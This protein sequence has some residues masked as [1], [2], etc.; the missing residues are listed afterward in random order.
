MPEQ[1]VFYGVSKVTCLRL[2]MDRPCVTTMS[3]FPV[4]LVFSLLPL[5]PPALKT[6]PRLLT[7]NWKGAQRIE[8]GTNDADA[9]FG[10]QYQ[11]SL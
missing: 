4:L 8:E 9:A 5:L 11:I 1:F 2:G 6:S 10:Y 3:T 7:L